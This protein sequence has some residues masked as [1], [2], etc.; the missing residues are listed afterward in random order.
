MSRVLLLGAIDRLDILDERVIEAVVADLGGD[1]GSR[2]DE[3]PEMAVGPESG[4]LEASQ[5]EDAPPPLDENAEDAG[6]SERARD[7]TA[8]DVR[9]LQALRD[10]VESLNAA[11]GGYASDDVSPDA[12]AMDQHQATIAQL[13]AR[14]AAAE[15]RLDE[16][17]EV[18]RRV[19][20]KLIEWVERDGKSGS[21]ANRAA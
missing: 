3:M 18:L 7:Q 10:E 5:E 17:D 8:D 1:I 11:M 12:P 20:S 4:A 2:M 9:D 14:L 13:E 15:T 21:V 19:L 6:S 16:Q